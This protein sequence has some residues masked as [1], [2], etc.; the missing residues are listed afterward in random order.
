VSAD[1]RRVP[2]WEATGRLPM[3][4]TRI[5]VP[6]DGSR[7]AEAVLPA[8]CS[9]AHKLGARLL[10]LHVLEREPPT[11]VHGEPHL[12]DEPEALAY[13][14]RHAESLR[15]RG[16]AV[17]VHVHERPVG[18]VAAA[19]DRHA[20]ELEADLI[21]MCAHGRTN[22][23]S[24]VVGSIAERILRGGSIPILLRTVR[25]PEAASFDLRRLLVPLD[26][27]HDVDAALDAARA[28]A[29]PYGASVTLLSALE[30][31]SPPAR[32]LPGT[33]ALTRELDL[34]ALHRRLG[35]I[36]EELRRDIEDVQT[37]V[38]ER[39][40]TEAIIAAGDALPADLIV[41]VTDAHGGLSAWYG[42]ST[43]QRLLA[44]PA[45]T[46]LLIKEL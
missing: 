36:A 35:E 42:P 11:T 19:I 17:D 20:H 26:F 39:G 9:V 5:L 18:D 12:G 25:G 34:E 30:P 8:A 33:S 7:L 46:L 2:A 3:H 31:A 38:D 27:G 4:F 10:L 24:R 32:M 23:R 14:E 28:L 22:L 44:R 43:A 45:L 40:P 16:I 13:V 41:L 15:G 1:T 37:I 21:A 29:R 6:L